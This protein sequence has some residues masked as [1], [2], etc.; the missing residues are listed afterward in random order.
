MFCLFCLMV[1]CCLV[2]LFCWFGFDLVIVLPGV[3]GLAGYAFVVYG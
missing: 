2:L 3:L 1:V